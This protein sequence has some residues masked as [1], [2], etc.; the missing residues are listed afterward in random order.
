MKIIVNES[1]FK[2]LILKEDFNSE[3]MH[4]N[5]LVRN[6]GNK[7]C[8]FWN[9]RSI[10]H[11][12]LLQNIKRQPGQF[13]RKLENAQMS[14][15][16]NNPDEGNDFSKVVL[17]KQHINSFIANLE[18]FI[19]GNCIRGGKGRSIVM[20]SLE[21]LRPM[22]MDL[23]KKL[24]NPNKYNVTLPQLEF[25]HG[26][27]PIDATIADIDVL[28]PSKRQQKS[29][30]NY[31]GFY[32]SPDIDKN[33]F[34][35]K[36]HQSNPGSGLHKITMDKDSKGYEYKGAIERI[37]QDVLKDLITNGYDFISGKN[38]FGKPEFILLNPR[39]VTMELVTTQDT[40]N[41]GIPNRLDIDDDNDGVLDPN[42]I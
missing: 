26:G 28:R 25:Y 12:D 4:W 37:S 17:T 13:V 5:K 38:V 11:E 34:A 31:A 33:S 41:D 27:L 20:N 10:R 30:T 7:Q 6:Y 29:G 9:N 15:D 32:M 19:M 1:Q 36:Y 39:R 35:L 16:K 22:L 21:K 2:K 3:K 14:R 8:S 18:N 24:E 40:D 23:M 42:D